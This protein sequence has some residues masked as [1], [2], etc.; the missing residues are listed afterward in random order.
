[1]HHRC[2]SLAGI[3]LRTPAGRARDLQ[4]HR[5]APMTH[6]SRDWLCLGRACCRARTPLRLAVTG[7][8]RL[9]R[10]AFPRHVLRQRWIRYE[11]DLAATPAAPPHVHLTRVTDPI[12][13]SLRQRPD[14]A[15]TNFK[16]GL[17]FWDEG[18][19]RAYIWIS[20]N[21]PLC[22]QWLLLPEDNRQLRRLSEWAGMHPPLPRGTGQVDHLFAFA[23]ARLSS[24]CTDFAYALYDEARRAGLQTLVTH[25]HES[26]RGARAWAEGTG[27][28]RFGTITRHQLGWPGTFA[29]SVYVHRD[30]APRRAEAMETAQE[31]A[32]ARLPRHWSGGTPSTAAGS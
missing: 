18:L 25:I 30:E 11:V 27:W 8:L 31:L 20:Q 4:R 24:V 6:D 26:D 21:G 12:I 10:A 29:R 9:A 22:M 19:R 13:A 17:R 23:A 2:I 14:R 16:L 1:M 28:R 32:R 5:Y 15:E 3:M 7:L